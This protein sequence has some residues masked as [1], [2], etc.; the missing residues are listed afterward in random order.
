THNSGTVTLDSV[1]ATE[2]INSGG[3]SFYNL[4]VN[5]GLVGYY[6]LDEGTG[7]SANDASGNANTG[8]YTGSPTFTS[9]AS[10]GYF[11][12]D[13]GAVTLNGSSQ[14]VDLNNP[15]QLNTGFTD[16]ITLAAWINPSATAKGEVI[17]GKSHAATHTS[18]WY[19]WLLY[20]T[21]NNALSFRIDSTLRDSTASTIVD[22]SWQHVAG[23]YD[24]STMTI[25]RNGS[26]LASTAKTGNIQTSDQNPRIG[27]RHTPTTGDGEHFTGS[28]DEVRIYKRALAAA[29]LTDLAAGNH[30]ATATYTLQAALTVA[31]TL[32]VVTGGLDVSATNCSAAPC[33]LTVTGSYT[34]VANLEPRTGSVTL[35]ATA[36]GKTVQ[37]DEAFYNLTFNGSGGGWTVDKQRLDV[38]N[39][40]TITA[41]TLDV[42]ASSCNAGTSCAMEIG[43]SFKNW[44]TFTSQTGTVT[45]NA[46]SGTTTIDTSEADSQAGA[47]FNH[48]TFND[49][50]G[51]AT[52]RPVYTLDVNGNL[53]VTGGTLDMTGPTTFYLTNDGGGTVNQ[54][55]LKPTNPAGSADNTAVCSDDAATQSGYCLVLPRSSSTTW[56]GSLPSTLQQR[57]YMF[58]DGMAISGSFAAGTWSAAVT[59]N[60]VEGAY[61]YSTRRVCGKLWKADAA[62]TSG[63]IIKD[64]TCAAVA[65]VG[66]QDTTISFGS[67]AA[68]TLSNQVV[69]AEFAVNL[70]GGIENTSGATT[71]TFRVNEGGTKQQLT[72]PA[73]TPQLLLGGNW[74]NND[75]FTHASGTVVLD[76]S[77]QQTVGAGAT[78]FS[79][80]TVTNSSGTDPESSPSA[81]FSGNATTAGTFTA[82]TANAKLRFNAGSTYTLQNISFNG[83]ATSTRVALRSSTTGTAWNLNVAGTRSVANTDVRD[84]NACGQAPNIDASDGT[85]FDAGGNSCWDMNTLTFAISDTSIGFGSLGAAA[86]RW[87]SGDGTGSASD[88]AAHTLQITTNARNGYA[89]TYNGA[90]LTSGSNTVSAATITDDADGTPGSEQFAIGFQTNGNATIASGYDHNTTASLRD[91]NFVASTATTAVSETGATATETISAY[92]LTNISSVT[93][94][95]AY[96]TSL[97]YIATATF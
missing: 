68:Q 48:L 1:A 92:Y 20:R 80:L 97:T 28:I 94:A 41:G 95:G 55:L 39:D 69:Y 42:S 45:M 9:G 27:M 4:T 17:V 81:I 74:T 18:P 29:E 31:N 61:T 58:N 16:K 10:S 30:P 51:T 65:G 14:Y 82:A 47:D 66:V 2:T 88:V 86:A 44:G 3:S 64:W 25:Y 11:G 34:N 57:G 79:G 22:G 35:N 73:F 75:L 49:G 50:G 67:L 32:N 24:G 37:A 83:Q 91:W 38:N 40:M 33:G 8:T 77:S 93:E 85:N 46:G 13:P 12:N 23:V 60:I 54:R 59:T 56:T 5:S 15:A 72:T 90:T 62:L 84:S 71:V 7:T 87:A 78:S 36:T 53:T 70:T 52:F 63:T 19:K 43:S 6:K 89:I 21:A 26:S 96:T 76:G